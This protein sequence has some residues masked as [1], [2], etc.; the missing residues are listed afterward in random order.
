M[1]K[2]ISFHGQQH[3][4]QKKKNTAIPVSY[5]E[6]NGKNR[7]HETCSLP[8]GAAASIHK[9][10]SALLEKLYRKNLQTA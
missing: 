9:Q 3:Q 5:L 4:T 10:N 2:E 1:Q 6:P 8:Y 7:P